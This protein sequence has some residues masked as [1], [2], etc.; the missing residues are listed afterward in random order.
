ML[1]KPVLLGTSSSTSMDMH[2]PAADGPPRGEDTTWLLLLMMKVALPVAEHRRSSMQQIIGA[3]MKKQFLEILLYIK[4]VIL[5][6][7][8]EKN[9]WL[10]QMKQSNEMK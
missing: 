10:T 9:V 1:I 3:L 5:Y 4:C 2:L 7:V 6:D 8:D